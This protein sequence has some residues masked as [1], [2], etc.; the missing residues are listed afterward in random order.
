MA[1]MAALLDIEDPPETTPVR[2][3]TA[4]EYDSVMQ[5]CLADQGFEVELPA[6]GGF[7]IQLPND[8]VPSF[9]LAHYECEGTFPV[10]ELYRR[11]SGPEEQRR[12]YQWLT[13]VLVPCLSEEGIDVSDPPTLE[14][15]QSSYER[16]QRWHPVNELLESMGPARVSD[17]SQTCPL[18]PPAEVIF[19]EPN[20]PS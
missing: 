2:V 18:D 4:S 10:H 12:E 16:P 13:E 3:I 20:G 15:F 7:D 9:R 8:Q 5:S 14:S 11:E 1:E 6:G 17:L 19:G